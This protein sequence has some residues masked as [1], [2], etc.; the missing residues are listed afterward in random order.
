MDLQKILDYIRMQVE[1]QV[2][3]LCPTCNFTFPMV[4]YLNNTVDNNSTGT[5]SGNSGIPNNTGGL[6]GTDLGNQTDNSTNGSNSTDNST[7]GSNSTNGTNSTD[8]STSNS[9]SGFFNKANYTLPSSCSYLNDFTVRCTE[10]VMRSVTYTFQQIN[11][12]YSINLNKVCSDA[13]TQY[14]KC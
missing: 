4:P 6:N 7:N 3:M 2:K 9:G 1:M 13:S 10:G 12:Y 8:N 11:S 5:G 14:N